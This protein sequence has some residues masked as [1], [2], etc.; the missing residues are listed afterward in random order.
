MLF[1]S[2]GPFNSSKTKKLINISIYYPIMYP[3][4]E[5]IS[6]FLKKM[7]VSILPLWYDFLPQGI[8]VLYLGQLESMAISN[9]ISS[10]DME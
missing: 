2:L 8:R 3:K 7:N 10:K 9:T 6:H 4:I 5:F 1:H